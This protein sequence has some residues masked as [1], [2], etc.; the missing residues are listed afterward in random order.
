MN[1]HYKNRKI[2]A[3]FGKVKGH[4]RTNFGVLVESYFPDTVETMYALH[5]WHVGLLY[6]N[7]GAL[8][9]F[10]TKFRYSK[11]GSIKT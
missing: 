2:A 8:L 6:E 5:T 1:V 7:I 3:D 9:L 11:L 10:R 4:Q